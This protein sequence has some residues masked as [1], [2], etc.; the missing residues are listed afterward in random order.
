MTTSARKTWRPVGIV[1]SVAAGLMRCQLG[2]PPAYAQD[3]HLDPAFGNGGKVRTNL[4]TANDVVNALAVQD[5][6]IIAAGVTGTSFGQN[7]AIARYNA[8]GPLDGTFGSGGKVVTDFGGA[9]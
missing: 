9:D 6:K 3:K 7:F 1:L 8:N 4:G 5:T 2:V